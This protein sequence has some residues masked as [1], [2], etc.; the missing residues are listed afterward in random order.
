MVLALPAQFH[1]TP[2]KI[3]GAVE[4][5]VGTTCYEPVIVLYGDCGTGGNLNRLLKSR[6]WWGLHGAH[7]YATYAGEKSFDQLMHEEPGTFFL[8]DYLAGSFDHLVYEGLGL[9][10]FPELSEMYFANYHRV[11][12]LQQRHDPGLVRKA[13]MAAASL[14]LP[15]EIRHTGLRHLEQEIEDLL[16]AAGHFAQPHGISE[17]LQADLR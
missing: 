10:R 17:A 11:V 5:R 16:S 7:C 8:T 3:P 15:L 9:D 14:G 12:Y 2:D 4:R 6:G 13:Q 1:N